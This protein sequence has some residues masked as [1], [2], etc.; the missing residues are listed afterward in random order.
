M[1]AIYDKGARIINA[2]SV[3]GKEVVILDELNAVWDIIRVCPG[4]LSMK[5]NGSTKHNLGTTGND[6]MTINIKRPGHQDVISVQ[7]NQI[8]S[9]SKG[10]AMVT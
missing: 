3:F 8:L 1:G 6:E 4:D 10:C 2:G 5:S 9:I 7:K